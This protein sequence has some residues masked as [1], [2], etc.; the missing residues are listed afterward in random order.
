MILKVLTRL[1]VAV[2]WLQ[3]VGVRQEKGRSGC[4]LLLTPGE[5]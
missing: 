2:E 1:Y 5:D 3:A 4:R